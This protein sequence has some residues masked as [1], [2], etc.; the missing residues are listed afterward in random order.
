MDQNYFNLGT[1]GRI[2]VA[3]HW[4]VL[5]AFAWMYLI[6]WNVVA[7][8]IA[9]AFFFVLLVIHEFGHVFVLRRLKIPVADIRLYGIHGMTT[10]RETSQRNE[11]LVAWGGVAAQLLVLVAAILVASFA[12]FSAVPFLGMAAGVA[13][14]VFTK[15]NVFVMIIALLPIGPFDGH[16]AWKAIPMMRSAARRRRERARRAKLFPE[17]ALAPE[18]RRELEE[19]SEKAAADLLRK[20]SGKGG[21]QKEDASERGD[22]G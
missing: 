22:G 10:H 20:F 14:V 3:M 16:A 17:E 4:S 19:K 12:D 11:T 7:S 13:Y 5:I 21:D 2:P 18:K 6:F 1:W 15:L 8:V 9:A